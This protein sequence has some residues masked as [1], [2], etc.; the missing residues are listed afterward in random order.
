MAKIN[1]INLGAM[2][3]SAHFL[4]ITDVLARLK[5]DEIPTRKR[6]FSLSASI[7]SISTFFSLNMRAKLVNSV[8]L[9]L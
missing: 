5:A 7:T 8:K 3:N 6:C 9:R 1:E 2:N 4:F